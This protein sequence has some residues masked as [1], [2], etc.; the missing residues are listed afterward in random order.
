M[1]SLTAT[2]SYSPLLRFSR[3]TFAATPATDYLYFSEKLLFGGYRFG[4]SVVVTLT[5]AFSGEPFYRVTL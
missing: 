2:L 3:V 5:A 1:V 4:C